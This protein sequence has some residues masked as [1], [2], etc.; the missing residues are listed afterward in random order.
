M[1]IIRKLDLLATVYSGDNYCPDTGDW[2]GL[3]S[4]LEYI[5]KNVSHL[6]NDCL[7]THTIILDWRLLI[8]QH[9]KYRLHN[10]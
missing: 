2:E 10:H 7:Y 9:W 6:H 5:S 4:I 3:D 1:V 8:A